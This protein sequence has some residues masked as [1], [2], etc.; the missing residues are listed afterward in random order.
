MRVRVRVTFISAALRAYFMTIVAHTGGSP[1]GGKVRRFAVMAS[2]LS[3]HETSRCLPHA[4]KVSDIDTGGTGFPREDL[5]YDHD[6]THQI[7]DERRDAGPDEAV[8][9]VADLR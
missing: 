5:T 8:A 7:G 1:E 2:V 9:E 4:V 6:G 3:K